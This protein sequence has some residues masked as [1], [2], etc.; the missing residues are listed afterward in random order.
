[1]VVKKIA[2]LW[3]RKD[4][5]SRSSSEDPGGQEKRA[6]IRLEYPPEKRPKFII[7]NDETEIINISERGLKFVNTPEIPM[8]K[9][10]NGSIVLSKKI[11]INIKGTV[12]WSEGNAAGVL[13]SGVIPQ[14]IM[15]EQLA[16]IKKLR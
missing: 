11:S 2:K 3:K 7:G 10:I 5:K 8:G 4:K 14:D 1:M 13:I 6:F 12:V 15:E 9:F 16:L